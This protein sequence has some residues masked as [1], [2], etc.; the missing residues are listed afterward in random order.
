M[1]RGIYMAKF[2]VEDI[3]KLA[4]NPEN[5]RNIGRP[6]NYL[7]DLKRMGIF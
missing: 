5:I 7:K 1:H 2:T 6:K 3:Q 4:Q